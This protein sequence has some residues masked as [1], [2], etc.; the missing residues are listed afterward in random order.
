MNPLHCKVI[1]I[2]LSIT[3]VTCD[4]VIFITVMFS[5]VTCWHVTFDTPVWMVDILR[6]F[7]TRDLC[8]FYVMKNFVK[9]QNE[10]ILQMVSLIIKSTSSATFSP[11]DVLR[12]QKVKCQA[13]WT[14][15]WG[16]ICMKQHK[17]ETHILH[18]AFWIITFTH[19]GHLPIYCL[20]EM[21]FPIKFKWISMSYG[22]F[23]KP[24]PYEFDLVQLFWL[25]Q[26]STAFSLLRNCVHV[27]DNLMC[28]L[29]THF[30]DT[31][32]HGAIARQTHRIEIWPSW[33]F[34]FGVVYKAET[35]WTYLV[36]S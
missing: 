11:Y 35:F 31:F 3:R 4:N 32:F 1:N 2:W 10:M 18:I 20:W 33:F 36:Q 9:D 30:V 27:I 22:T 14:D 15:E 34:L 23:P 13:F 19:E 24:L 21:I 29:L 5:V 6:E 16:V 8:L 7:I 25:K 28:T 26:G 17:K 12:M